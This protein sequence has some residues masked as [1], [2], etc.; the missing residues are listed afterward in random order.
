MDPIERALRDFINDQFFVRDEDVPSELGLIPAGVV[1]S[2]GFLEVIAW[3]EDTHGFQVP[4]ADIIEPIWG[5]IDKIVAY[6]KRRLAEK[7]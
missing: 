6:I 5:G 7:P 3:V 4:D 2:T 1:D